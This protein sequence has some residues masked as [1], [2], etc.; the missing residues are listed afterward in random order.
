MKFSII[1][2]LYTTKVQMLLACQFNIIKYNNYKPN[3]LEIQHMTKH[4]NNFTSIINLRVMEIIIKF[5]IKNLF[6]Y[7]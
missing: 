4:P 7:L 6:I 2:N 1:K 3:L 5:G